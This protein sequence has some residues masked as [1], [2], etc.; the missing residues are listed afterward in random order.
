[1]K[2]G[3]LMRENKPSTTTTQQSATQQST[4]SQQSTS[5]T[6]TTQQPTPKPVFMRLLMLF[7][8]G[9]GCLLVGIIVSMVTGDLVML[10]M[11][12]VLGIA[13]VT[14]GI[15]LIRKIRLGHIYSVS[16]VCVSIVPKLLGR[17]RRIELV[18]VSSGN[19]ICFILP[20]KVV[21]KIGHSY[22]C[23]FDNQLNDQ[24]S[25]HN[26]HQHLYDQ[27][28]QHNHNH[29]YQD[30]QGRGDS[31]KGGFFNADM[32]LPTNGFLGFEDF[33]VY[34]EK[35]VVTSSP[36]PPSVTS[37]IA[38]QKLME[39]ASTTPQKLTEATPDFAGNPANTENTDKTV[40]AVK[41]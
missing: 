31:S 7:G 27:H 30:R 37:S 23:Y 19:D 26:Q 9:V 1:M 41:C 15:L 24:H 20:K 40:N 29:N 6:T 11:S 36:S 21:F 35:P 38:P 32:D 3:M 13:F 22:T 18:D 5:N 39:A 28:S 16:G 34:Q 17:Y 33:G 10:A 4:T 14:K 12:A 25:H 8:G 2:R